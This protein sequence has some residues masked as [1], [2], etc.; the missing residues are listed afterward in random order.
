[1]RRRAFPVA[2][3]LAATVLLA[4]L[5]GCEAPEPR[6]TIPPNRLQ[7]SLAAG[8]A[9]A[10]LLR[11]DCE[12]ADR[13]ACVGIIAALRE[14]ADSERCEPIRDTGSRIVVTGR[15][16]GEPVA[17]VLRRR[18]DCEARVYDRVRRALDG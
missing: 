4:A 10:L 14:G 15:I 18:T 16:A 2:C 5:A 9:G 7:V 17:R 8:E 1:V 13:D 12:I 3:A 11:L 6:S